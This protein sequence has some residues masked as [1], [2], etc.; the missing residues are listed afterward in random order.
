MA[1]I[2]KTFKNTNH[3]FT[4]EVT[5][6]GKKVVT[7]WVEEKKEQVKFARYKFEW[8]IKKFM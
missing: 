6:A 2:S 3:G 8:M 4:V 7:C 1:L 5:G